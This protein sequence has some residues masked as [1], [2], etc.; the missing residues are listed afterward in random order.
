LTDVES[1]DGGISTERFEPPKESRI[2]PIIAVGKK[3]TADC[4]R[5]LS[6]NNPSGDRNVLQIALDAEIVV[7]SAETTPPLCAIPLLWRGRGGSLSNSRPI[8]NTP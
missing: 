1:V 7:F 6:R 8:L 4:R 5:T 3:Q 2:I